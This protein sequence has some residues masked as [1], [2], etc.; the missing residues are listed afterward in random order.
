MVIG[1][2]PSWLV[3]RAVRGPS[4]QATIS[5]VSVTSMVTVFPAWTR[6]QRDGLPGDHDHAGV[7]HPALHPSW[8][9]AF[10]DVSG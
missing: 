5:S 8:I 4:S 1:T 2:G 10:R 3:R 9:R 6:A 7:G